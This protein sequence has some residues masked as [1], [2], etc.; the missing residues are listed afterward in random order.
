MK[1]IY[2][3]LAI[4]SLLLGGCSKE[5]DDSGAYGGIVG[6]VSDYYTNM[7]IESANITLS[8]SGLSIQ[9]DVNGQYKFERLD[10]QQYT[11]TVQKF[12]YQPDRKTIMV[13]RGELQ[14]VDIQL[15]VIPSE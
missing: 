14:N 3:L 8:P 10:V 12:G 1:K 13:Y 6:M 4:I 11:L 15:T 5:Y 2:V 9:T 7:P